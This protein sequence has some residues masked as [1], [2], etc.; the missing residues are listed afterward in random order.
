MRTR[1]RIGIATGTLAAVVG[2]FSYSG[3]AQPPGPAERI[4]EKLDEAGK[5][6]KRGAR[7]VAED[8][9]QRFQETR[10][11]V[12]NMGVESRVYG[13]LHWDKAL[14][15]AVLELETSRDGVV[16]LRGSVPDAEVKAKALALTS[17][18][19]GVT[20]VID[21]LSIGPRPTT[22]TTTTTRTATTPSGTTKTKTVET[23][24]RP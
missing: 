23:E 8:F 18:T 10:T 1:T 14:T 12:H 11:A 17:D 13:R 6:I 20:R 5:A 3:Q 4:G 2:A 15:D 19:V 21:Q 16:T 9:R 24:P 22:T 7:E